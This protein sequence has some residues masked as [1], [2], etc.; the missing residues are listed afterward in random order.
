MALK[1]FRN[2]TMNDINAWCVI[3]ILQTGL[4]GFPDVSEAME[5]HGKLYLKLL[6]WI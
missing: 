5:K 6:E 3:S 4:V 1:N 2:Y